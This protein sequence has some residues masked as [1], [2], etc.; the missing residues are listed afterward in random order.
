MTSY[1]SVQSALA[2]DNRENVRPASGLAGFV[3][4]AY[5]KVAC[6]AGRLRERW[7]ARRAYD[8]FS[9][10]DNH[11]LAD[12]GSNRGEMFVAAYAEEHGCSEPANNNEPQGPH[13]VESQGVA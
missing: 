13:T 7:R 2:D 9:R 8:A 5:Q 11:T 12:I 6:T 10:L 4:R 3:S 1:E